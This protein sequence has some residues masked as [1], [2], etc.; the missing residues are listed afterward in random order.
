METFMDK[1]SVFLF[2]AVIPFVLTL[3]ACGGG[4]GGSS[5]VRTD[6]FTSWSAVRPNSTVVVSG[7]SIDAPYTYDTTTE[8]VT[9]VGATS[10]S[11]NAAVTYTN[12]ANYNVTALTIQTPT[13]TA[14]W[15]ANNGDFFGFLTYYPAIDVAISADGTQI[16]LSADP[17]DLGWNYQTF[18]VW[19]I[20]AGAPT[21]GGAIPTSGSAI[22][23]GAAGGFYVDA[24]GNDYLASSSLA[25]TANFGS[26]SL[27]FA[28]SN[29]GVTRDLINDS[30]NPGINLNG[31]LT[32]EAGSNA[33]TGPVTSQSGTL[34]GTASGQFYGPAAQEIGG[35]F[36]LRS[37]S[38]IES[39]AGAFGG[40][41]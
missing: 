16:G 32:Y 35:V 17:E 30:S 37:N 18:G 41:R 25:V 5:N 9:S 20:S 33:F 2:S 14:S 12:D 36:E 3:T 23:T 34:A 8:K 21:L 31:T 39:Y 7:I 22:Y 29:S 11:N 40:I 4:G 24:S 19:E 27:A 26:R 38:T 28:T 1:K 10:S 6:N 13:S 15:S